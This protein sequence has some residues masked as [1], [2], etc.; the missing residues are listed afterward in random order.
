M[1][2]ATEGL[3]RAYVIFAASLM[4][5]EGAVGI[6]GNFMV[7]LVILFSKTPAGERQQPV[8]RQHWF[9]LTSCT[10]HCNICHG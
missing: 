1:Q 3:P 7:V 2:E 4:I 10:H 5:T 6:V 8:H 9:L